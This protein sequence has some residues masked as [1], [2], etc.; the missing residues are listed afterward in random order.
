M[1]DDQ[2]SADQI[3]AAL[4]RDDLDA[5]LETG[6]EVLADPETRKGFTAYLK[7]DKR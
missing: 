3:Q 2:R 7:G 1:S 5:A 6:R 4:D